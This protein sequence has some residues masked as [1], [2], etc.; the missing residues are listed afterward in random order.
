MIA[1]VRRR[2]HHQP[3]YYHGAIER[4][5]QLYESFGVELGELRHVAGATKEEMR[6][7]ET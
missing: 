2:G 1:E 7:I 5:C 3:I 6:V 4:L